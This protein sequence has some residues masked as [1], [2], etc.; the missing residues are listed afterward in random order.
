M[1]GTAHIQWFGKILILRSLLSIGYQPQEEKAGRRVRV[2][3]CNSYTTKLL[4]ATRWRQQST[5]STQLPN[6]HFILC[7]CCHSPDKTRQKTTN[8]CPSYPSSS[9]NFTPGWPQFHIIRRLDP[10]HGHA[11]HRPVEQWP[12]YHLCLISH[13]PLHTQRGAPIPKQAPWL[14]LGSW[15][16]PL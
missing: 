1:T 12:L 10:S 11:D 15:M 7:I 9:C 16:P 14:C 13:C 2:K 5:R 3:R 4:L 8:C 6:G